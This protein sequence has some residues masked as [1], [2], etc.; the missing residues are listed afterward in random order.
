MESAPPLAAVF[1][2]GYLPGGDKS[3]ATCPKTTAVAIREAA[4]LLGCGGVITVLAY[5]GHDGGAEEASAVE[6]VLAQLASCEWLRR[7]P[8]NPE[9][10]SPRLFAVRKR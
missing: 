5:V 6:N 4:K 3:I 8:F 2:L 9:T 1:N 7:D 10:L